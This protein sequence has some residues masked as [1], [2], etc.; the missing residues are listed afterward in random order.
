MKLPRRQNLISAAY[1]AILCVGCVGLST[2]PV[3]Q[4]L[5]IS[6]SNN[7][8]M[9][10]QLNTIASNNKNWFY[11]SIKI[12]NSIN[13]VYRGKLPGNLAIYL[14]NDIYLFKDEPLQRYIQSVIDR[15]L[16]TW[17]GPKIEV[18]P[19]VESDTRF[20]AYV[21][22]LNQLHIS[23]GLLRQL[24]SEDMLAAVLAHELAHI[25]LNHSVGAAK[26]QKFGE[27]L[28]RTS[29]FAVAMVGAKQ[30]LVDGR[31]RTSKKISITAN[32]LGLLWSDLLIPKY[33]RRNELEADRLGIDMLVAA[34]YNYGEFDDVLRRIN[35]A[36]T[37]RSRRISVIDDYAR[38]VALTITR[39]ELKG[40]QTQIN[41]IVQDFTNSLFDSS[42]NYIVENS[43]SHDE[44]EYRVRLFREYFDAMYDSDALPPESSVATF[45][46][47]I[48][49]G[50]SNSALERDLRAIQGVIALSDR[51]QLTAKKTI[52]RLGTDNDPARDK[53]AL[54]I[55]ESSFDVAQR[56]YK[57]ARY[58]LESI[59]E[60]QP[61]AP[62]EAYIRLARLQA[63]L[64]DFEAA[65]ATLDLGKERIGR[66]YRFIPA[67]IYIHK[68]AGRT[69][70]AVK[71]TK[72]CAQYDSGPTR[73]FFEKLLQVE[74]RRDKSYFDQ[75][76]DILG[77]DPIK[78]NAD[79]LREKSTSVIRKTCELLQSQGK[80]CKF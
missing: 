75:C 61:L 31:K 43:P 58:R 59:I 74:Y 1:I 78:R 3:E 30:L 76:V 40:Q 80:K 25:L 9:L 53:I 48:K 67:R 72:S 23:T 16:L 10:E 8:P 51:D 13:S 68:I 11:R 69:A 21:D 66:D 38:N 39:E 6:W 50:Q 2:L 22:P 32:S 77:F 19:V 49:L 17:K 20:T 34:G 62:A 12:D 64:A 14:E 7:Q 4:R 45:E 33:N 18:T 52:V 27:L 42:I 35:N 79:S 63:Y 36:A 29:A 71:A 24:E 56:Q 28:D 57:K 41:A 73:L 54:H 5:A 44:S 46:A 47:I 15:L 60:R 37:T 55:A 70:A 65:I 26:A